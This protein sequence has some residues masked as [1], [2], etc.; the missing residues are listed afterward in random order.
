GEPTSLTVSA[1]RRVLGAGAGPAQGLERTLRV[2]DP[3][4][5]RVDAVAA[6]CDGESDEV[7]IF[8]A[9]HRYRQEWD[10]EVAVVPGGTT[11]VELEWELCG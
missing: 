10:V 9:C 6:A 4:I 1:P 7:G 3:G 8:A 2:G 11:A 5:V